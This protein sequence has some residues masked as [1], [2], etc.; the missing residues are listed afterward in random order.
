MDLEE[1]RKQLQ[2]SSTL[3]KP[4]IKLTEIDI[5]ITRE[6]GNTETNDQIHQKTPLG[7]VIS[8]TLFVAINGVLGE[9]KNGVDG[10][11][12]QMM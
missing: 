12:L 6:H 9:L 11:F 8:V 3:R 7:Q 2:C 1:R 4:R 5:Q 10:L